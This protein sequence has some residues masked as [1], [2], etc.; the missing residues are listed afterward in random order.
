MSNF[1]NGI[2]DFMDSIAYIYDKICHP[3]GIYRINFFKHL[4]NKY[5]LNNPNFLDMSCSTGETCILLAE[6]G[7]SSTGIDFSEQMIN[8]SREKALSKNLPCEFKVMDMRKLLFEYYNFDIIFNNSLVWIDSLNDVAKVVSTTS[9]LLTQDNLFVID[10]PN[11][12]HFLI[13]YKPYHLKGIKLEKEAI[14]KI[15]RYDN[16]PD[17]KEQVM[18]TCQTYV[19]LDYLNGKQNVYS[20]DFTIR[21]HSLDE[22]EEILK[23]YNI[24]IV[25]I[26]G[27]YGLNSIDNIDD[28]T[29]LQIICKKLYLESGQYENSNC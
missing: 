19:H 14:Y 11:H 25:E 27:D 7:F 23:K 12:N 22:L 8:I 13:T 10:I 20:H 17:I 26:I 24:Q 9:D 2:G 15:V 4:V 1:F 21:L 6:N 5:N 16:H 18:K 29:N 3:A 28:C